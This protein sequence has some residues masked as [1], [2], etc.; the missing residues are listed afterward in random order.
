MAVVSI[1]DFIE[2]QVDENGNETKVFS[3]NL[4]HG[5]LIVSKFC[6]YVNNLTINGM[7]LTD[8][9]MVALGERIKEISVVPYGRAPHQKARL[10]IKFDVRMT[11]RR[12]FKVEDWLEQELSGGVGKDFFGPDNIMTAPDGTRY[13]IEY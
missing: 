3:E 9:A 4:P 5:D 2:V 10:V 11:R 12:L 8:Y 13:Y 7:S 1:L 6:D